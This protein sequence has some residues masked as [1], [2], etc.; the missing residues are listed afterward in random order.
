MTGSFAAV[1]NAESDVHVFSVR[2]VE[3][4]YGGVD[5]RR[6]YTCSHFFLFW[7]L[8]LFVKIGQRR[9]ARVM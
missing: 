2:C 6:R 4:S 8:S 9:A 7:V 5:N 1:S 3:V